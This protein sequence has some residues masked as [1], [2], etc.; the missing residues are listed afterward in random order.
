MQPFDPD[1]AAQPG[2]GIFGLPHGPDEAAVHVLGVPFDATTSYRRGTAHGPEAVVAA[3]AQ[4]DL[5]DRLFGKPYE[6]GIWYRADDGTLAGWNDQARA[7]ADPV[8]AAGGADPD[9]HE[10]AHLLAE[11]AALGSRVNERVEEFTTDCL[12]AER[13]PVVLGGDHS[14]PFGAIRA[15]ARAHPGLGVLHFDAH[16][17]LRVA[18]EGFE[19]SH[20]SIFHNVLEQ[21]PGVASLV[22]VGIRDL[23]HAEAMRCDA[24][25]RIHTLFDDEWAEVV[26]RGGDRRQAI[27]RHLERLPQEVWISFD[28]DGLS[29]DLCPSTGTP[30][31]G[32]LDWHQ[33]MQWLEELVLRGHRIVGVDLCEVA[34]PEGRGD[35]EGASWDAVVGA[36]LLYRLIGA[37]MSSRG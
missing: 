11:L 37:A 26:A 22:Q 6:Q 10:H 17:D 18:F 25:P 8:I 31:P 3:S 29:P 36:R 30:V 23:G 35:P 4:V 2:S 9:S 14:V 7:L 32:G 13:L 28:I 5:Y 34:P 19:W 33:T 20:A 1:A 16:A 21:V 15:A 24:D 12:A 27:R